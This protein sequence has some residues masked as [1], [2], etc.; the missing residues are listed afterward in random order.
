MDLKPQVVLP[1]LKTTI[2]S[3]SPQFPTSNAEFDRKNEAANLVPTRLL[4]IESNSL[5]FPFPLGDG[6]IPVS[7]GLRREVVLVEG[8][9]FDGGEEGPGP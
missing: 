7:D 4:G 6:P 5:A 2:G 3:P 9:R 1:L 8:V